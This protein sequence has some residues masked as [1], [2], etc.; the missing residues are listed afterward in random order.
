MKIWTELQGVPEKNIKFNAPQ[1]YDRQSQ[2][3]AVFTKMFKNYLLTQ[4]R[5]MFEQR[6]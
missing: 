3:H 5:A 2:S 4:E 1:L 6:C